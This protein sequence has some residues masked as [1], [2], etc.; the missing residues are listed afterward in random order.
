MILAALLALGLLGAER[1][2]RRL[3]EPLRYQ[4]NQVLT[5]VYA[6]MAAP[7]QLAGW[8]DDVSASNSALR[9]ENEYL[10][11]QALVL[12]GRLQK[13][14]ALAAENARFRGLIDSTIVTDGR[15]MIA[16]IV[17]VDPDPLRHV[18]MLDKGAQDGIYIGQPIID[19]SGIMGQV[20]E[21]GPTISRALLISDRQ[22]A[23]PARINRNGL[24][25]IVSGSGEIDL[26]NV[27]Y[28][29]ESA[30]VKVGDLIVTSGLGR[31]FPAGYPV[32]TVVSVRR[33]TGAEFMEIRARPAAALD[34][35]HH[36]L[37]LFAQPAK[38]QE[39]TGG[40]P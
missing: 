20:I 14:A 35:S 28:V 5:P 19:A 8:L 16:E 31:L 11:T 3:L 6:L 24:R 29:P 38:L 10:R 13:F 34:R 22:H 2:D 25:A 17:G 27:D 12:Q 7:T 1:Y 33:N 21:L 32:G 15:V 36:V 9:R 37:F 26:L 40:T 30:D 18:I 39:V 23:V 4:I